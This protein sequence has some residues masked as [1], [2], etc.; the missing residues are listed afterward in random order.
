ML[1]KYEAYIVIVFTLHYA[2]IRLHHYG[3]YLALDK[4]LGLEKLL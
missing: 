4:S 3:I 1:F 2:S